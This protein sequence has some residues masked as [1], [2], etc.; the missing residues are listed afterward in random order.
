VL[1]RDK[2]MVLKV[3]LRTY[4]N[5]RADIWDESTAEQD[6]GKLKRMAAR[7]E[8]KPGSEV[9]DVG[10]GTGIFLPFIMSSIGGNGRVVALDLA[11]EMLKKAR[12]KSLNGNIDY[13]QADIMEIPLGG[14]I[15]DSVV[16]YSTFPHF[17][18]KVKTLGEIYRVMKNGGR[19]LI[20]H[21]SSRAHIN[22]IHRELPVVKDD[23][24]PAGDEMRSMLSAAGFGEIRIEDG[25]DSY[26]A[27]AVKF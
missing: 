21:T 2:K 13:L 7:L 9:L 26:L 10:T 6:A 8:L 24:L 5:D 17:Q 4:F 25:S 3:V 23:M 19:L 11:E 20:C 14:G 15:F 16:C 12:A 22:E 1:R 18:D 27:S